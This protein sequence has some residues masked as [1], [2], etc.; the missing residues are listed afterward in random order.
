ME[1]CTVGFKL[2]HSRRVSFWSKG[3]EL[4]HVL[5]SESSLTFSLL[6]P[7]LALASPEFRLL[8]REAQTLFCLKYGLGDVG[9]SCGQLSE[10][11]EL[12]WKDV[13][14]RPTPATANEVGLC[15]AAV[16]DRQP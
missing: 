16:P 2:G 4:G 11:T 6:S 8:L 15:F 9:Q 7:P 14:R 13:S 10:A 1:E 5:A 12:D 3:A